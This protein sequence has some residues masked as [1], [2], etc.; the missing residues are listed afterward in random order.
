MGFVGDPKED[1]TVNLFT[2]AG[3]AGTN[4]DMKSTNGIFLA[5][6]GPNT[7]FPIAAQSK[8]QG[9]VSRSTPE[10]ELI[11]M[12]YGLRLTGLPALT[13]SLIHI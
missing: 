2:D 11:A 1:L 4:A 10:A 7:F 6:T 8:K 13:L 9:C 12:D 3:Y 5:I